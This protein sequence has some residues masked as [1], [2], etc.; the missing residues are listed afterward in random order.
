MNSPVCLLTLVC[1]EIAA[2]E[3]LCGLNVVL[4]ADS[5]SVLPFL[6]GTSGFEDV[7]EISLPYYYG[8]QSNL[9]KTA[10]CAKF[11]MNF[12]MP[13]QPAWEIY[14]ATHREQHAP[15]V[16]VTVSCSLRFCLFCTKWEILSSSN[17]AVPSHMTPRHEALSLHRSSQQTGSMWHFFKVFLRLSV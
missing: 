7:N 5:K 4:L 3:W 17:L 16:A 12:H 2:V 14:F 11:F 13:E 6:R 10:Y 1:I 9:T 15:P 8:C